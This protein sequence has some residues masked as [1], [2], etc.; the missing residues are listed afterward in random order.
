[1]FPNLSQKLKSA[2]SAVVSV[3]VAVL[4]FLLRRERQKNR[5]LQADLSRE[6]E[7]DERGKE[8]VELNGLE[9]EASDA[10]KKAYQTGRE[11][12]DALARIPRRRDR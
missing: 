2:L 7:G 5:S 4:Y 9:K 6:I 12:H 3:T 8:K 10:E 1:M 11:L